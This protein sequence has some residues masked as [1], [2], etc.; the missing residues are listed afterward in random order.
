AETGIPRY[1]TCIELA[2]GVV[3]PARDFF[4]APLED[5]HPAELLKPD[6]RG[7]IGHVVLEPE[8]R[9]FVKPVSLGP[10]ALPRVTVEPVEAHQLDTLSVVLA[11][12]RDHAAF[13][14]SDRLRRVE[15]EGGEVTHRPH[16]APLVA[17]RK[18]MRSVLDDGETARL[19]QFEDR[20]H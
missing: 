9:D 10:I 11:L 5:S 6:C 16:R 18:G 4:A 13:A 20:L 7:E 19:G 8:L 1:E 14:R 12:R 15:A 3:V 2:E 17:G